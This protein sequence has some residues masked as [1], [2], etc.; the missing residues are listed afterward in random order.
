MGSTLLDMHFSTLIM[1]SLPPSYHPAIQTITTA[2]KIGVM[3]GTAIRPKMLPNGLIN[4]FT[5]EVQHHAIDDE[6]SKL[7]ESALLAHAKKAKKSDPCKAKKNPKAN[8]DEHCDN[9]SK[10]GHT[11]EECWSKGGGKEGQGP[12]QKIPKK[13]AKPTDSAVIADNKQNHDDLFMFT[14][15]T[16]F[17]TVVANS[18]APELQLGACLD[19]GASNHYFPDCSKFVNYRQIHGCEIIV[20]DRHSLKAIGIGDVQIDLPN[21]NAKTPAMLK[22]A[23]HAPDMAFTLISI[24][25]LDKAKCGTIFKNG[26]CIIKNPMGKTMAIIPCSNGLYWTPVP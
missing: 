17:A 13:G 25:H 7:A 2:E 5:E 23:I 24:G 6:H 14:C 22:D 19:S 12:R 26:N 21:G 8:P 1:S 15:A 18:D 4:F 11:K 20:A 9:C 10:D 16:S 3:H